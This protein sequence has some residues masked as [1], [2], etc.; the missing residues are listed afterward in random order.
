MLQWKT[1]IVIA[2]LALGGAA[3]A[4]ADAPQPADPS[5]VE[6]RVVDAAGEPVAGATVELVE[7]HRR[8]TTTA[9]GAFRFD[10]LAAGRYLV[11][12]AGEAGELALERVVVGR[13]ETAQV[14][15]TARTLIHREEIVVSASADPRSLLEVAQPVTVLS[16]EELILRRAATLGET[17][18]GQAGVSSTWFGPGASRPILRGQGGERVRTLTGGLGS[19]DAS[20]TSPDHAVS[21]EPLVAE[22]IEVLRGPATLRYGSSAIG[23]VVNVLDGRIPVHAAEEPLSGAVEVGG[24]TNGDEA[25]GVV[26]LDGGGGR[27]AWHVDYS[28][29]DVGDLEIPGH[30]EL[31]EEHEGEEEEHEEEPGILENS[32]LRNESGAAGISWIGDAGYVGLSVSGLDSDYGVPGHAHEE[33]HE[34]EEDVE[35]EEEVVRI[36][37]E[38]RRVD[39]EGRL[40]RP[41]GVF[42]GLHVRAG[43]SE[44]EHRELEGSEVGT[45][46]TNDG[47]EGRVELVQRQYGRLSG[48]VGVQAGRSDFTAAGEEAFVPPSVTD[49]LAG[50]TFQNI[51]FGDVELELGARVESQ[52][53]DPEALLPERS[54][55]AAS[56]SV[57]AVWSFTEGWALAGSIARTERAPS[58]T[59]L[60]ANGP[61]VA[62]RTFEVGDPDLDVEVSRG[63]DLSL[64]AGGERFRGG[65]T[66]F[67]TLYDGYI[68]EQPTALEEDGLPVVQFVQRDTEFRG[69]ELDADWHLLGIEAGELDLGLRAS[70]VRAELR[71]SGEPLPRIPPL[72]LGT[73]LRWHA[74]RWSA[75]VEVRWL[76][77]QDRV[78]AEENETDGYT[79]LGAS[80]GYRLLFRQAVVD[81]IL[82]GENLTDEEA[83]VHTSFLKNLAP[84]PGRNLRLMVRTSF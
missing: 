55:T 76:D 77:D 69:A 36:D 41:F 81:F 67:T 33:E 17:L 54:F 20:A 21:V 18:S 15:L 68:F 79:L 48:S 22:S 2:C 60:Y 58:A 59:E 9:D 53:S 37:L 29:R 78:A 61:H 23:G 12:V 14:T 26:A 44:Y 83:R 72:E 56:G 27:I 24:G 73:D 6:G 11:E 74:P 34:G 65:L 62:T 1:W 40:T 66:L 28:L 31:E 84:L 10:N 80:L 52:D 63:A 19:A 70:L 3:A 13:G 82:K 38:Q 5:A 43:V 71:D 35:E 25:S 4:V 47:Y 45:R 8:T 7:L 16:G 50:F 75:G 49:S 42:R 57:G 32:S 39:L 64:K 51:D 46:F 30:A